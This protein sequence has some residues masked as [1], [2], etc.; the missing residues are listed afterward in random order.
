MLLNNLISMKPILYIFTSLI[1]FSCENT[2]L[3]AANSNKETE[4]SE[5][6]EDEC[7]TTS[8]S[9]YVSAKICIPPRCEI[10]DSPD[11]YQQKEYRY[12]MCDITLPSGKQIFIRELER[13]MG[14]E[15]NLPIRRAAIESEIPEEEMHES[16]DQYF[17]QKMKSG[18]Y[19]IQSFVQSDY[20]WPYMLK[21]SELPSLDDVELMLSYIT[22]FEFTPVN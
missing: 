14:I 22:S 12:V 9:G 15:D 4:Q 11:Y 1:L 13:D 19:V 8:I 10:G 5:T 18:T 17:I 6:I 20:G 2:E 16:T 7:V 3:D 21:S